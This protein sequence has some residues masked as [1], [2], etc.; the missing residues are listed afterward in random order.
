MFEVTT[1]QLEMVSDFV[2]IPVR[3]RL[4]TCKNQA[5]FCKIPLVFHLCLSQSYKGVK[6]TT[7][8]MALITSQ[9]C[10]FKNEN[11]RAERFARAF[12]IFCTFGSRSRSYY[13]VKLPVLQ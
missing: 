12:F 9:I 4:K 7:M 13:D 11:K 1:E 8:T 10:I 6:A 5:R 3:S 2:D